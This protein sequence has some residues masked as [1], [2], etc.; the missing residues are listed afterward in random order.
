VQASGSV[1]GFGE[2]MEWLDA[3]HH[4]KTQPIQK[5]PGGLNSVMTE[6]LYTWANML[7]YGSVCIGEIVPDGPS[8]AFTMT[9]S[10]SAC[11][12]IWGYSL[13]LG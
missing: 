1:L 13:S 5:P 8:H 9:S 4:I 3:I 10:A 7:W 11:G 2:H 12:R 6:I